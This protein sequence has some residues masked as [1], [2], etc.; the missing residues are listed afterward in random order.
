[1]KPNLTRVEAA[2]YLTDELGL[3]TTKGT[4][5]KLATVGGGPP[6]ALFGNKTIYTPTNLS[7]WAAAKITPPKRST[8]ETA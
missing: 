3:P 1:M 8:S 4:L 5:Q 2:K 7:R 6:Y